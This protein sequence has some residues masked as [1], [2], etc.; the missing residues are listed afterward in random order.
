MGVAWL[1]FIGLR[2]ERLTTFG[3]PCDHRIGLGPQVLLTGGGIRHRNAAEVVAAVV[4][5]KQSTGTG[6][7]LPDGVLPGSPALF[8]RVR[9]EFF[10]TAGRIGVLGVLTCM[11][12]I[13]RQYPVHRV[14]PVE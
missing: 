6:L 5:P 12:A 9:A 13:D 14:G 3:Q 1:P 11:A 8:L 2:G 4:A 7:V 10:P